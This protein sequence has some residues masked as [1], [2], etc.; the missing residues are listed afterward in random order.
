M[1][2]AGATSLKSVILNRLQ[3]KKN[4]PAFA[5]TALGR[6][7]PHEETTKGIGAENERLQL[8]VKELKKDLQAS[9]DEVEKLIKN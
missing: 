9:N 7:R 3:E 1:E 5:E 2:K 8:K 4:S 6:K